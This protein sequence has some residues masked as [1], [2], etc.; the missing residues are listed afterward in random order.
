MLA[1][2]ILLCLTVWVGGYSEVYFLS[3]VGIIL[4]VLMSLLFVVRLGSTVPVREL[5]G[6]MLF[7]Q[8][9]LAPSLIYN[10]LDNETSYPM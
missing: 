9:V 4:C 1:G 10:Y 6:F 5:I 2:V 8:L 3:K 7:L